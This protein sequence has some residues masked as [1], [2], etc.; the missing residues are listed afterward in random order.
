MMRRGHIRVLEVLF[1]FLL[2][3][4]LWSSITYLVYQGQKRDSLASLGEKFL[5]DS[6]LQLNI[7]EVKN[8]DAIL[9]ISAQ[10]QDWQNLEHS[11][12]NANVRDVSIETYAK[13]L[14]KVL[15]YT[16]KLVLVSWFP[17]VRD[18]DPTYLQP[19]S[20]VLKQFGNKDALRIVATPKQ[21]SL[22]PF[23]EWRDDRRV[24][25]GDDCGYDVVSY[26]SYSKSWSDR[27]VIQ[28]LAD[29]FSR[30]IE[31]DPQSYL[32]EDLPNIYPNYLVNVPSRR[33]IKQISFSEL[34]ADNEQI[35]FDGKI[36]V[37][38]NALQQDPSL[39]LDRI[40]VQRI[41]TLPDSR[42]NGLAKD[43]TPYHMFWAQLAQMFKDEQMVRVAP[44]Y[45]TR[46]LMFMMVVAVLY[47]LYSMRAIKAFVYFVLL[48]LIV[49]ML[50]VLL[51]RYAHYYIPHFEVV[52]AGVFTY[53]SA[54]F[55]LISLE[56]FRMWRLAAREESLQQSQS[57]KT[58]FLALV[59]HNL[60]TPVAKM[61]GL[62]DLLRPKIAT[63]SPE[64]IVLFDGIQAGIAQLQICVRAVLV[65]MQLESADKSALQTTTLPQLIVEFETSLNSLV[66]RLGI[67]H[68][69]KK[70]AAED[71][72]NYQPLQM[73]IKAV[74]FTW[75]AALGVLQRV[76]GSHIATSIALGTNA[77]GSTR[78]MLRFE[79]AAPT[80][81]L[82]RAE[83]LQLETLLTN[84]PS[85]FS[86]RPDFLQLCLVR[87]LVQFADIYC[88]Q[89]QLI[90]DSNAASSAF[91]LEFSAY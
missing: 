87:L 37:I 81:L 83:W 9:V 33:E 80:P 29:R 64:S 49:P 10:E 74:S 31:R 66:K 79:S 1:P 35:D 90:E 13:V 59:S 2:G 61:Q 42:R 45:V 86:V 65:E 85:L 38:G 30:Q 36:V 21:R 18:A 16:P 41:F 71:E 67:I 89:L 51:T 39:G 75:A 62:A 15:P 32:S 60:N 6:T 53:F 7:P 22:F 77:D 14:A 40:S 69:I 48:L 20:D 19:I 8:K 23:D 28:F 3:A 72:I 88:G 47:L 5:I 34:L 52:Y 78:V 58:H 57:L 26:C 91:L 17:S 82:H 24:L 44:Q 11:T 68:T 54:A 12:A 56:L 25:E 55:G 63:E 4:L 43:G 70:P 46:I 73:D 84:S 27:W 76:F 50:N